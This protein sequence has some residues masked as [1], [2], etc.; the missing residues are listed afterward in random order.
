MLL[1][2]IFFPR[3]LKAV[4]PTSGGGT[5]YRHLADALDFVRQEQGF[6]PAPLVSCHLLLRNSRDRVLEKCK[7]FQKPPFHGPVEPCARTRSAASLIANV[8]RERTFSPWWACWIG[9]ET[10]AAMLNQSGRREMTLEELGLNVIA[11]VFVSIFEGKL[12][13]P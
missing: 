1:V 10:W 11:G 4:P 8:C 7:V 5:F 12:R 2:F 9:P 6:V 13:D 3:L